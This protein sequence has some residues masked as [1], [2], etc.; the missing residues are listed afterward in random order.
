[1]RGAQTL[2]RQCRVQQQ[3]CQHHGVVRGQQIDEG[4]ARPAVGSAGAPVGVDHPADQPR[5]RWQRH[6]VVA[7]RLRPQHPRA[8][9]GVEFI[10][11]MAVLA[12][13]RAPRHP[14]P[15][16][17]R[18]GWERLPTAQRRCQHRLHAMQMQFRVVVA[19]Q[20]AEGV[21]GG[22]QPPQGGD[23]I[24]CGRLAVQR[25]QDLLHARRRERQRQA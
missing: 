7:C 2:Y 17:I 19:R 25:A 18:L 23:D 4:E 14:Q 8:A 5:S 22:G 6:F 11:G 16:M 10:A 12:H 15:P 20:A 13:Y 21:A 9:D 3:Q 1:M 24:A